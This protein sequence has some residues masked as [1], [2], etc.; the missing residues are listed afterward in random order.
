MPAVQDKVKELTGKE[1]HRGVNPD[2]VVAVGA[3]IQAG[4][5]AGDVKDVL[6]LDVTPL[7]LGIETKG[8]V[9]TKLIE[10]NTTIPTRKSEVFSTAEDNQPSVEIHVLQGEREMATYN[11]SLGKFQLTGIPPAPRGIPQIEVA[12]DIDANGILH[13]SAK[14]LGTGKEQRIEIR[15]GSGLAEDEIKRMVSDAESHADED[16]RLRELAEA[17]N[18]GE[19]AAYQAERQVKDLGDAVDEAS[20]AEIDAALK[21]L[22]DSLTSEDAEEIKAKTDRLQGA[23]H[24]VSEAMY[25]RAQAAQQQSNGAGA[26]AD[27]AGDEEVVDAEVVD[28]QR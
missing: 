24:K 1:P 11:K 20:K 17:R 10:R 18:A 15:A 21:E 2:E 13:V 9:M 12:F 8:G 27:G 25:E 7:T 22:R 26:G 3:A 28:E 4:V 19:H 23:F 6:L 14:D 5:L 16:R